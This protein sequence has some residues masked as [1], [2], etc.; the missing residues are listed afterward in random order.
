MTDAQSE[1]WLM[2]KP[3]AVE[4]LRSASLKEDAD[5]WVLLSVLMCGTR[6]GDLRNMIATGD[7]ANH[8]VFPFERLREGLYHLQRAGLV[9]KKGSLY[10]ASPR[11]TWFWR[12]AQKKERRLLKAWNLLD[13]WLGKQILSTV[14]GNA[15]RITKS[16]YD[17]AVK[18]Y[19]DNF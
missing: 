19:L 18:D 12:K 7:Y 15:R 16:K 3:A 13:Q 14:A 9:A 6:G 11:A 2:R 5:S 8:A 4:M 1:R 10:Y 17:E